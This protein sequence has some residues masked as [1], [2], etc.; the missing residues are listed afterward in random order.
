MHLV[1]VMVLSGLALLPTAVAPQA[2]TADLPA[3][4]F[5][6]GDHP[7]DYEMAMD[8]RGGR[9]GKACAFIKA[10][11]TTPQGFG[12]LMQSFDATD[13]RGKR[14]RFS[15]NVK[16]RSPQA[17][18]RPFGSVSRTRRLVALCPAVLVSASSFS[19]PASRRA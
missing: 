10:R 4:W 19:P 17:S 15:A 3:G 7:A 12:T 18:R 16:A 6:A 13:Y 9:T 1:T 8:P 11:T 2:A 5:R 14:L